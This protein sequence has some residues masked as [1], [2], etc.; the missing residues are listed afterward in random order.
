MRT[1]EKDNIGQ[2][3]ALYQE[4][5]NRFFSEEYA[6]GRLFY[7]L[8]DIKYLDQLQAQ[9]IYITELLLSIDQLEFPMPKEEFELLMEEN[10][11]ALLGDLMVNYIIIV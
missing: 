4:L 9:L 11:R 5:N 1:K 7:N 3:N 6:N 10:K 2:L 8:N